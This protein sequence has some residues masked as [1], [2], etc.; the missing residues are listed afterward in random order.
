MAS[1]FDKLL[2]RTNRYINKDKQANN[3]EQNYKGFE[4]AYYSMNATYLNVLD[5][6]E[7]FYEF[8]HYGTNILSFVGYNG[9]YYVTSWLCTSESDRAML[10]K[11]LKRLNEENAKYNG[12]KMSF[13]F[14]QGISWHNI[15]Y[16]EASKI[17]LYSDPEYEKEQLEQVKKQNFI[18]KLPDYSQL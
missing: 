13:W 12:R 3:H 14:S 8:G 18:P 5:K 9:C 6:N 11:A 10:E 4:L 17:S 7:V 15:L 2:D 16:D 1:Y